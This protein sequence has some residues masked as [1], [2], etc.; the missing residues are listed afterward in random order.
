M[1]MLTNVHKNIFGGIGGGEGG[2]SAWRATMR[3]GM[4]GGDEENSLTSFKHQEE[5]DEDF[6]FIEE[7]VACFAREL[8]LAPIVEIIQNAFS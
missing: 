7:K 6:G 4:F 2:S 1:T 5:D 3:S 8:S